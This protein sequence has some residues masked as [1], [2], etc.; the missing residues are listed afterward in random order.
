MG[1]KAELKTM[2]NVILKVVLGQDLAGDRI[3]LHVV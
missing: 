3:Q 2:N 1:Q